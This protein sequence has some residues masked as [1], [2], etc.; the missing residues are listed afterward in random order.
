LEAMN[1]TEQTNPSTAPSHAGDKDTNTWALIMHLSLLAGFLVPFAGLIAPLAIYLIKKNDLPGLVPHG[2]VVFN[3]IIS[4]IIYAVVGA[5]LTIV[6]IGV[7]IL[8]ALA[9]ISIIFP[10]I[11]AIKASDGTVWRYPLSI[12]IFKSN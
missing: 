10:I 12:E 2:H 9:I 3:W 6:L 8:I 4:V 11:G 7:P 1:E 5:I